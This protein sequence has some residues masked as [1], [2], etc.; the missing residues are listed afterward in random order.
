MSAEVKFL[1]GCLGIIVLIA[2]ISFVEGWLGA[3]VWNYV[4]VRAFDKPFLITWWQA[5]IGIFLLQLIFK[6][7]S[8]K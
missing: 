5:F 3:L 6:G 2:V 4:A 1:G 8:S 7:A